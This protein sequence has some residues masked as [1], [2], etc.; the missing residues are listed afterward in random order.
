MP[1]E[2]LL[3]AC[4]MLIQWNLFNADIKLSEPPIIQPPNLIVQLEFFGIQCMIY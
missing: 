4:I 2:F 3:Q 1:Q